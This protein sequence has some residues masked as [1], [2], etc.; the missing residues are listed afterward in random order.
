MRLTLDSLLA[1]HTRTD[2]NGRLRNP[3]DIPGA[4][5][6]EGDDKWAIV[7]KGVRMT[8][9]DTLDLFLALHGAREAL[10]LSECGML[11]EREALLRRLTPERKTDALEGERMVAL[12][13]AAA[14]FYAGQLHETNLANG[15]FVE[16]GLTPQQIERAQCGWAGAGSRLST[17]LMRKFSADD[18][19]AYGLGF[20]G[21]GGLKDKNQFRMVLPVVSEFGNVVGLNARLA[22]AE[23]D[24]KAA[25][26]LMADRKY[27][28]TAKLDKEDNPILLR[29]ALATAKRT[30]SIIVCEGA[31]D[32]FPA[33]RNGLN[34]M[35]LNGTSM[36]D[37]I[38]R[39]IANLGYKVGI[40]LDMDKPGR[41]GT[42]KLI[43]Q[44]W[45]HG[46][47]PLV[48]SFDTGHKDIGEFLSAGNGPDKLAWTPGMTWYA[49][50][51]SEIDRSFSSA[52][53]T[54]PTMGSVMRL[55]SALAKHAGL[56][57]AQTQQLHR[58]AALE[59]ATKLKLAVPCETRTIPEASATRI[60]R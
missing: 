8:G 52:I 36:S 15:M 49:A 5:I 25:G 45:R 4:F 32:A 13:S 19:R 27:L 24:A 54:L 38:V 39:R 43:E 31:F 2:A 51:L 26:D 55:T 6:R 20:F 33:R 48:A 22:R 16:R 57:A 56:D 29:E 1:E 18:I 9:G 14:D 44:F 59:A 60:S 35:S 58:A 12:M 47:L 28:L 23:Q 41:K 17:H 34:A 53:E 46:A 30:K 7:D 21:H 42:A 37:A 40:A 11:P 10:V 50:N 3:T